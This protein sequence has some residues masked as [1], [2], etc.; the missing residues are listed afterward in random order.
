[1]DA[2][3]IPPHELKE[4]EKRLKGFVWLINEKPEL[5]DVL[6][7]RSA[8]SVLPL[9]VKKAPPVPPAKKKTPPATPK[10]KPVAQK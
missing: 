8:P 6:A 10:Q 4:E 7:K 1:V 3:F 5:K 9:P 2:S